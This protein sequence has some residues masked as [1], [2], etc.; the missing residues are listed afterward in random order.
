[1]NERRLRRWLVPCAALAAVALPLLAGGCFDE[2]SEEWRLMRD[3]N[4]CAGC[5]DEEGNLPPG[6]QLTPEG[7]LPT[8]PANRI[9]EEPG[10]GYAQPPEETPP[11]ET[12][13]EPGEGAT[14]E[15]TGETP[16]PT[17]PFRP[18]VPD[19]VLQPWPDPNLPRPSP[20]Y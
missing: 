13:E 4:D 10:S 20:T 6:A 2:L 19:G 8:L 11:G 17:P 5:H 15:T 1:M 9:G 14:D 18:R 16:P 7:E 12:A 3:C